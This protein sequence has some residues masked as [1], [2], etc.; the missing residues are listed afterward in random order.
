MQGAKGAPGAGLSPREVVAR[1]GE[2]VLHGRNLEVV[3]EIASED[4]VEHDPSFGQEPG[5]E[6]LKKTL[7]ALFVAFPDQRWE[8][9]EVIAEGEKVVTRF[10]F[11]GTNEGEFMGM[12][13]TG[14]RVAVKGGGID[15]VVEGKWTESRLLMDDLG[16]MQQLGVIPT[17]QQ[18]EA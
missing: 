4:F 18:A 10:T 17:P 16:M 1:F 6:G 14:R 8:D 5:R 2:E 3:D 11:Y 12:P 7:A 15:R 13:P 9:E